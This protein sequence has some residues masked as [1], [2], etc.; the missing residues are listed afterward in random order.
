MVTDLMHDETALEM[1]KVLGERNEGFIQ[2]SYVPDA[3]QVRGRLQDHSEKH[4][5][6]LALLSGRPILYNAIAVNDMSIRSATSA[7]SHGSK[8]APSAVSACSDRARRSK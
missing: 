4:Y 6:E 8:A 3:E 5:E 7:S 2:M 1:A